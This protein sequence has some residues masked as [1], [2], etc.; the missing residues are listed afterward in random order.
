MAFVSGQLVRPESLVKLCG[1]AE[2]RNAGK[3]ER[4]SA[5][6]L[7]IDRKTNLNQKKTFF[8]VVA[9]NSLIDRTGSTGSNSAGFDPGLWRLFD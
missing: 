9:M 8:C 3:L 2:A 5:R 6:I 1:V 7:L 4:Y